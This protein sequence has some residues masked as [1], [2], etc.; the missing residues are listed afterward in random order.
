[1]SDSVEVDLEQPVSEVLSGKRVRKQ[2][3]KDLAY[4]GQQR[5]KT[6]YKPTAAAKERQKANKAHQAHQAALLDVPENVNVNI[7]PSVA[8]SSY[9]KASQLTLS[10]DQL[11]CHGC[12]VLPLL[13]LT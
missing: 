12:E 6:Q 11:I 9:D 13:L 1:M 8:L 2:I 7:L 10:K 4:S 5:Q 3:D